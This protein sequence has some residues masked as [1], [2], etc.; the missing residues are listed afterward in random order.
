MIIAF[1]FLSDFNSLLYKRA[2]CTDGVDILSNPHQREPYNEMYKP[3]ISIFTMRSFS[4]IV[5]Q[6]SVFPGELKIV[7]NNM[8]I[9]VLLLLFFSLP[10]FSQPLRNSHVISDR[11]V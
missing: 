9:A 6:C 10:A 5:M 11:T 7:A 1:L 8:G 3:L 4:G 2:H